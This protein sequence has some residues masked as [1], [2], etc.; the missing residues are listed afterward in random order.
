MKEPKAAQKF[1][2]FR[3]VLR[4][5]E[6][7]GKN[8]VDLVDRNIDVL[9][10]HE[11][12]NRRNRSF[13]QK[14]ADGITAVSGSML[15]VLFHAVLFAVWLAINNGVFGLR[16]FDPYPYGLL[17]TIVSLEAIFLSIF[18]LISQNRMQYESDRR[19][20]LDLQI[21]L[22][23]E[24]EVTRILRLVDLIGER[25]GIEECHDQELTQLES[26]TNPKEVIEE[27][28]ARRENT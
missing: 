9:I 10:E 12:G 8:L 14:I 13:S 27:I 16:P 6:S 28:E 18:V 7:A 1:D 17:T 15:F 24:Y 2:R 4:G 11:E 22:L 26:A 3:G 19:A 23:T 21:N 20:E 5:K 25:M